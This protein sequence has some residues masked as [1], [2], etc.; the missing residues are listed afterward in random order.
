MTGGLVK[1]PA[2]S[3]RQRLLNH[4]RSLGRP[5]SEILQHYGMERFLYRLS[6]SPHCWNFV[7]KGALMFNI[8]GGRISRPTMDIDL[9][10]RFSN[11]IGT[12][13]GVFREACLINVEPDGLFFDPES[14]SGERIIEGASYEGIR[15]RLRGSLG[16]AVLVIRV[17]IGFG[18]VIVPC[19]MTAS[20]PT[21]LDLPNPLIQ[22]YSKES[23]IAE[24]FQIMTKLGQLNSRLKDFYDIWFLSTRFDFRGDILSSAILETFRSRGTEIPSDPLDVM[25]S[26]AQDSAKQSQW[27]SFRRI[28]FLADAPEQ[29]T[30]VVDLVSHF[31]LP[32]C[33]AASHKKTLGKSWEHPGPWK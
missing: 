32:V 5:F 15:V 29:L 27:G 20:Y 31:L 25:K 24:K 10:G 2:A 4:A 26:L 12:I 7:L 33:E 11:D 28:N 18:D 13:I 8:W 19:A 14:V 6:E 16:T 30:E 21:I 17:D 22:G 3:V 9:L 1:N 23:L